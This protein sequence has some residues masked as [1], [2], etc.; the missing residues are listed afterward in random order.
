MVSLPAGVI[1]FFLFQGLQVVSGADPAFCLVGTGASF[2]GV[3]RPGREV[4]HSPQSSPELKN[5]WSCSSA[6]TYAF[7]M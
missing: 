4:D 3:N 7:T 5:E 6:P 2:R 1:D